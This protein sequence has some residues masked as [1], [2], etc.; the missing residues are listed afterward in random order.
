MG[1]TVERRLGSGG[2][3]A[4]YLARCEGR[5]Y[6]LKLLDLARVGGRVEREVSILLK[7]SHPNVVGLHGFG[8]WP[9]ASPSLGVIVMEYVE[10]RQLDVW[11]S[12]EN[13]SA[14]QVAR[15]VLDVARALE[16][17]HEAGVLHRDV[18][19]LNVMVRA[20]DGV[21][22]LVDFGVGDYAGAPGITV[23]ILP[24]GTPEYRSPEAWS[25]FRRNARV[26]GAFFTP[27]ASDDLWALG[28]V[29][30]RLLTARPPFPTD[31]FMLADAV[32]ANEALPPCQVNDRV[33]A[34]L[35]EVCMALLAKTPASRT[36]SAGALRVALE[37]LLQG[38]DAAWDVPLCDAYGDDTATTEGGMD[39]HEKWLNEALRR[40]RRGRRP[41]M[42]P[43]LQWEGRA[44]PLDEEPA[45]ARTPRPVRTSRGWRMGAMALLVGLV[46]AGLVW[47]G[48]PPRVAVPAPTRQEVARP[49]SSSQAGRAAALPS[50][51]ESTPA[52]VAAPAMLPEATPVK[53]E[54]TESPTPPKPARK[55]AGAMRRPIV[56]A[57]ACMGLAC[58]GAQVRPPPPPEPCPE[59]AV[60]VMEKLG[61]KVGDHWGV[62]FLVNK[63]Q[64]I[65]V[66]DG[67][68]ELLLL[69]DWNRMP[70]ST[71]FSGR[72]IVSDRVY[73]RFTHA[74]T[75]DGKSFPVCLELESEFL[76][77]GLAREPGDDSPTSAR[78][79]TTGDVRA[80]D[81]FE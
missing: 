2:F 47:S 1:Y 63:P 67:P 54:K 79:F 55:G 69:A 17:S 52:A 75:R 26:P 58:P 18:K 4:V 62:S 56:A 5:A 42:D 31:H 20:S 8:E 68:A 38:A 7:L 10:G 24:P 80:V 57:A 3:G 70:N 22:K 43:P 29:L 16:A 53:M 25:F 36:P 27:G 44:P 59:R 51:A 48:R 13:P 64:V 61:V 74:R 39:S 35:S 15:V 41:D 33:P 21:A 37:A 50:G 66:T 73:G 23:D 30:Y 11:A 45:A 77:K 9:V 72:L 12:E 60:E 28:V 46:S 78:V 34:A 6:A 49:G 71:I 14:R 32:I 76:V 40:P 19:E 65:K 81:A